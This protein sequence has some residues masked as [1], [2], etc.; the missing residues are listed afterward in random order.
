MRGY[1]ID[2]RFHSIQHILIHRQSFF[3]LHSSIAFINS[4]IHFGLKTQALDGDLQ[5]PRVAYRKSIR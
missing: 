5:E 2:W 1:F 4:D 3:H